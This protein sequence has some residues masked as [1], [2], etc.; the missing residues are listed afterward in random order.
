MWLALVAA[1]LL[2]LAIGWRVGY[3]RGYAHGTDEAARRISGFVRAK[4][5]E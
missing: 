3:G 2:G 4:T 5:L 1:L